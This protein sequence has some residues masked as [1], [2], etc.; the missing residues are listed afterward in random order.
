LTGGA[1]IAYGLVMFSPFLLAGTA[2]LLL[3]PVV[4]A[5][6]HWSEKTASG[7]PER[8]DRRR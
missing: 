5:V 3:G 2:L 6:V 4:V 8:A 7:T 1:L